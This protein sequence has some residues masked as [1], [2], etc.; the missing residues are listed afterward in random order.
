VPKTDLACSV[1]DLKCGGLLLGVFRTFGGDSGRTWGSLASEGQHASA[2]EQETATAVHLPLEELE[3]VHLTFDLAVA[4][5]LSYRR[6][7]G[8]VIA[9][10]SGNEA[11]QLRDIRLQA[12]HQPRVE[13]IGVPILENI[14]EPLSQFFDRGDLRVGRSDRLHLK[15]FFRGAL[16]RR[17][18]EPNAT[19]LKLGRV[20]R[21]FDGVG[22]DFARQGWT[23]SFTRLR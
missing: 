22:A 8:V 20:L 21:G 11:L 9:F 15:L 10:D 7:D 14:A 23:Y 16:L 17:L 2:Q 4:P 3:P 18:R 19:S 6:D 5:G 1:L 13:R 12:S